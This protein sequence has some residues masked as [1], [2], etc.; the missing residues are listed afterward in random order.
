M[1]IVNGWVVCK[2]NI[3]RPKPCQLQALQDIT[4]SHCCQTK[5]IVRLPPVVIFSSQR[6]WPNEQQVN[7]TPKYLL[8]RIS[9][10]V[11]LDSRAISSVSKVA[12]WLMA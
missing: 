9:L 10:A 4:P 5:T 1:R 7:M 3:G 2:D 6:K 12:P 8:T 11:A